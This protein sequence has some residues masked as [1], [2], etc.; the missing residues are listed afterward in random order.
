[1]EW[2]DWGASQDDA[3]LA[4]LCL[5]VIAIWR[6]KGVQRQEVEEY[7]ASRVGM[8]VDKEGRVAAIAG[9]VVYYLCAGRVIVRGGNGNFGWEVF[10][11]P[12]EQMV[13][14]PSQTSS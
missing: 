1:M 13:Q 6:R 12:P 8:G 2:D 14:P 11:N 9:F 3:K 10:E 5:K 7:V 4:S